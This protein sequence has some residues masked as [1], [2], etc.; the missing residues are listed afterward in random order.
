MFEFPVKEITINLPGWIE[1]LPRD[2]WIKSGILNSLKESIQTLQKLN[3]VDTS[4]KALNEL[5]IV[6]DVNIREIK[7]G[8]GI[9]NAEL[10][11]DEALFFKVLKG[12][13]RIFNRRRLSNIRAN[14]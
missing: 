4:L 3:E 6:R 2:H 11:V 7:L 5:D 14:K 12:D 9:V 8:E 10:I 1:G 13:D